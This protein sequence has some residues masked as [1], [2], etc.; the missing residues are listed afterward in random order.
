[1]SATLQ[2]V[3]ASLSPTL[4]KVWFCAKL[5]GMHGGIEDLAVFL[6]TPDLAFGSDCP[7]WHSVCA[8]GINAWLD[9]KGA[10]VSASGLYQLKDPSVRAQGLH[11]RGTA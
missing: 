6:S 4:S 1:M 8:D 5:I 7:A 11:C 9:V 10:F 3:L 2:D